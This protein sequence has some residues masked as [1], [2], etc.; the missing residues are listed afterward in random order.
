MSLIK[1]IRSK[2]TSGSSDA[3]YPPPSPSRPVRCAV[4][5]DHWAVR[6]DSFDRAG[7]DPGQSRLV[8]PPTSQV[9]IP[10]QVR[11]EEES[12]ARQGGDRGVAGRWWR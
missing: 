6:Q 5:S 8:P 1:S 12:V 9:D 3:L 10:L 2:P 11:A 4:S 7:L